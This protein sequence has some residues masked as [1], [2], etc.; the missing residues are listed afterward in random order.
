MLVWVPAS[1]QGSAQSWVLASVSV[2]ALV[3]Q[4]R[5]ELMES[6]LVPLVSAVPRKTPTIPFLGEPKYWDRFFL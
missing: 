4:T 1:A 2:S 5:A 6:A 3:H